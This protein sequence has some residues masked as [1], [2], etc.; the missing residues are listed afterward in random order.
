MPTA[1]I[2]RLQATSTLD[3]PPPDQSDSSETFGERAWCLFNERYAAAASTN[4]TTMAVVVIPYERDPP[5]QTNAFIDTALY[6][7][8]K[9]T[10]GVIFVSGW[11]EFMQQ[12]QF[13]K[14]DD[15][16]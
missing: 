7:Q 4:D 6:N 15:R 14:L 8:L 9:T 3:A 12:Y 13:N 5:P 1:R 10:L 2:T 16:M 11:G